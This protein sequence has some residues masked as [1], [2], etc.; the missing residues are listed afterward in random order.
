MGPFHTPQRMDA[1]RKLLL[2]GLVAAL[3][4]CE[5][6]PFHDDDGGD[7]LSHAPR[8]AH[9]HSTPFRLAHVDRLPGA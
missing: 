1:M 6:M 2:I 9:S 3:A 8:H 7:Y 4:G 5:E